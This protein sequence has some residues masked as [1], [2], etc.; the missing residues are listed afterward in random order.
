VVIRW[1]FGCYR[2]LDIG[3][4]TLDFVLPTPICTE[5]IG[6]AHRNLKDVLADG[7]GD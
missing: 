6:F 1:S 7:I 3:H 5:R 2:T 4:W